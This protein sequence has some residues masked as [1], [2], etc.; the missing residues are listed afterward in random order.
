MRWIAQTHFDR[1]TVSALARK[2]KR[3]ATQTDRLQLVEKRNRLQR[4]V[5]RF[6]AK[7]STYWRQE[8]DEDEEAE[9][10]PG[11]YAGQEWEDVE[12]EPDMGEDL[13]EIEEPEDEILPETISLQLPSAVGMKRL[14]E[15]GKTRL[16]ERELRLREG[17]ANDAL[18]RLRMAVGMKSVAFVTKVRSANSQRTKTR[19]WKDVQGLAKLIAEQARLYTLA[20]TAM[21]RLLMTDGDASAMEKQFSA[22]RAAM[23]KDG[24]DRDGASGS[25]Q[26]ARATQPHTAAQAEAERAFR[27]WLKKLPP[28]LQRYRPLT[29]E[30]LNVTTHLLDHSERNT[31]YKQLS[32]IWSVDVGGDTDN[33]EWLKECT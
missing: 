24:A 20:R 22:H 23:K 6:V 26:P 28:L 3:H 13:V 15:L 18:H 19:A 4:A 11:A 5:D 29:K 1:L 10:R 7:S 25:S 16:G 21:K 2:I 30:D 27:E 17:Q 12:E 31:R 8:A 14:D 9:Q 33:S 32:W